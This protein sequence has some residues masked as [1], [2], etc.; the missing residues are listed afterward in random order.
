LTSNVFKADKNQIAEMADN[1]AEQ[2][3]GARVLGYAIF[4]RVGEVSSASNLERLMLE[5]DFKG[6]IKKISLSELAGLPNDDKTTFQIETHNVSATTTYI[7]H[8]ELM[9]LIDCRVQV[10]KFNSP[11][12]LVSVR[13]TT[14]DAHSE[15]Y[16]V[17]FGSSRAVRTPEP[18]KR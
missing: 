14:G 4:T 18:T 1:L 11:T 3:I 17:E 13:H 5:I 10:V 7:P 16:V 15:K 9:G 2:Y 12:Q 6:E 8:S